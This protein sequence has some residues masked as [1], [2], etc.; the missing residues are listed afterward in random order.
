MTTRLRRVVASSSARRYAADR[1]S[2]K[3]PARV[4]TQV[5]GVTA[6]I[7]Q[8]WHV[9][10]DLALLKCRNA[11][12][13]FTERAD[14]RGVAGISRTHQISAVFDR[15]EHGDQMMLKRGRGP[16]EPGVIGQVDQKLGAAKRRARAGLGIVSS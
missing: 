9:E 6:L 7:L 12:N 1:E 15:P 8:E 2:T 4:V 13:C 5:L 11:G 3:P 16:S 14:D 10:S